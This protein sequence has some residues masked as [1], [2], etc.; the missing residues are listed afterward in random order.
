MICLVDDDDLEALLCAEVDLLGLRDFLEQIL[1]HYSVVVPDIGGRDLEVVYGGD[2]VELEFAVR[3]GLEDARVDLD[4][5]DTGTVHLLERCDDARLFACAR[6]AV[7]E[8]MWK[9]TALC[10]R[11]RMLAGPVCEGTWTCQSS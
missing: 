11:G 8:E 7:Y 6:R 9:V 4:L 5:L 2:D 3:R 1:H 10:L